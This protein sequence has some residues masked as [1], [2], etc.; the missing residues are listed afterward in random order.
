MGTA[1]RRRWRKR[2]LAGEV[3]IADYT[4]M[5]YFL[6]AD[7][8]EVI[9]HHAGLVLTRHILYVETTNAKPSDWRM[10]SSNL[11]QDERTLPGLIRYRAYGGFEAPQQLSPA[12]G[13]PDHLTGVSSLS[14]TA[15][16]PTAR[17]AFE[18]PNS[19]MLPLDS[20]SSTEDQDS[21]SS[22]HLA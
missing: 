18:I 4:L 11:R 7:D 2:F 3:R 6:L 12:L 17:S 21:D 13:S 16:G 8:L 19:L 10:P 15:P 9:G 14:A 22:R 1:S 20:R 5:C